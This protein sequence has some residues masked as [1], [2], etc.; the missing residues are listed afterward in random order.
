MEPPFSIPCQLPCK[1]AASLVQKWRIDKTK[2]DIAKL[3]LQLRNELA[4]SKA[5]AKQKSDPIGG[6]I[7]SKAKAKPKPPHAFQNRQATTSSGISSTLPSP[8]FSR[9]MSPSPCRAFQASPSPNP[10]EQTAELRALV[11][12]QVAMSCAETRVTTDP[13]YELLDL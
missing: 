8:T 10:S 13:Y 7:A 9:S 3:K 1:G 12:K 11:D 4:A 6:K 2:R 5:K